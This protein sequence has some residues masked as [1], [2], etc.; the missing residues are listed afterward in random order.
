MSRRS[1]HGS[2]VL[3]PEGSLLLDRYLVQRVLGKGASG[4]VYRGYDQK[5]GQEVAIKAFPAS[6]RENK[7][8]SARLHREIRSAHRIQSDYVTKL[9]NC[10]ITDD[11]IVLILEY[12]HGVALSDY[13][14]KNPLIP[15]PTVCRIIRQVARGLEAI[16]E[17]NIIHRDIKLE[18]I[19]LSDSG[20]IKITDFGI[21]SLREESEAFIPSHE[22]GESNET[23]DVRHTD[24]LTVKG[25]VVGTLQYISP[26]YLLGEECDER[27]DIYALGVLLYELITGKYLYKYTNHADLM[28]K[29][30]NADPRPPIKLRPDCPDWLN[31]V[32]MKALSRNPRDR[33]Q[34]AKEVAFEFNRPGVLFASDDSSGLSSTAMNGS[35]R[36]SIMD[37]RHQSAVYDRKFI[38]QAR[39]RRR[40]G[41]PS[42]LRLPLE[43]INGGPLS[44]APILELLVLGIV[45][46]GTLLFLVHPTAKYTAQEYLYS[47]MPAE[48]VYVQP[49]NSER[50]PTMFKKSNNAKHEEDL[51]LFD[52]SQ[53]FT[54]P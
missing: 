1:A 24:R 31:N 7:L 32:C 45:V 44:H 38:K 49:V 12:V 47:L 5:Y 54:K 14:K 13:L 16:H 39:R 11:Y 25:K 23:Q 18:N 41:L 21:S 51:P 37:L 10:H 33:Y 6:L 36:T 2:P 22:H 35:S 50:T 42:I 43:F 15:I 20:D 52:I 34:K 27:G 26:E 8:A 29:K 53:D 9:Y 3:I 28:E 17:Q 4:T 30:V 40:G 19:M 48:P 46:A